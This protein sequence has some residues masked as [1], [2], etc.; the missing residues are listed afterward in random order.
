MVDT[1]TDDKGL[2]RTAGPD[3]GELIVLLHGFP[4][5]PAAWTD[6]L[7]RLAA[8][9]YRAV[10]PPL[11]G[12]VPGVAHQRVDAR[13]DVAAEAVLR[14]A[15]DRDVERFH[16][17]GHDWGANVGWTLAAVHPD[18]VASF[19]ALSIPH[20]GA[21]LAALPGTQLLRSAYVPVL[22]LPI[23]TTAVSSVGN[24]VVLRRSLRA[25]G[26]PD[27]LADAY[28]DHLVGTGVLGQALDWYRANGPRVLGRIVPVEVPTTFVW[29]WND[30]FL[31][32]RAA[33]GCGHWVRASYTF[34]PVD[35]GHWLP[36]RQPGLVAD[37]VL[38]QVRRAATGPVAGR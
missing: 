37:H 13:V 33:E 5:T 15:D 36:E 2:T 6:V 34:V 14:L 9:G 30:P 35:E 4:Q 19:T 12:F 11:P 27:H 25:S 22:R 24:G 28:V 26:V 38:T 31:G 3:D 17:V 23:V 32:R 29:G 16:V 18:R 21:L 20:P 1:R 10:A 7:P 8:A